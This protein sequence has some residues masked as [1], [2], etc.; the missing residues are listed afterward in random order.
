M[1]KLVLLIVVAAVLIS[2]LSACAPPKT[3]EPTPTP[4]PTATPSPSPSPTGSQAQGPSASYLKYIEA[5]S[6]AMDEI[7]T[8]IDENEGYAMSLGFSMLPVAMLD[9]M[10]VPL[11]VIDMGDHGTDALE[12]MGLADVKF[13]ASGNSYTVTYKNEEGSAF[14]QVCEY[15]YATDSLKSTVSKD[16]EEFILVEYVKAGDGYVAQYFSSDEGEHSMIKMFINSGIV[17]FGIYQTDVRP[18]SIYKT[19]GHNVN[20]VENDKFYFILENNQI[21]MFEDGEQ[22]VE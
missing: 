8:F 7:N 2:V 21:Q 20:F 19:S 13:E 12:L 17:A 1:K 14:S 11:S 15:D 6:E 22:V 18:A 9:L 10:L 16:G 4:T 3:P 5:K